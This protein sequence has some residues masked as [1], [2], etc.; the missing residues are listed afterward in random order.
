MRTL[1]RRLSS[2][3]MK[4]QRRL[5]SRMGNDPALK[6]EEFQNY[7]RSIIRLALKELIEMELE[8][9]EKNMSDN[10]QA[11]LKLLEEIIHDRQVNG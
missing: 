4:I 1:K 9:I 6:R 10:S 3:A 11:P 5:E 8:D 2:L 7:D